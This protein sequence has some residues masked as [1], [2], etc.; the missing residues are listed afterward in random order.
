[1]LILESS[2]DLFASDENSIEAQPVESTATFG[3]KA[4][5]R[6]RKSKHVWTEDQDRQLL[7]CV[8]LYGDKTWRR[9]S[10]LIGKT[11]IRCHNRYLELMKGKAQPKTKWTPEEDEILT[12][13]V[14]ERG[15]R[16][17][18][19]SKLIPGRIGKQCRERFLNRLN[20][21]IKKSCWTEEED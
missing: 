1:M 2:S 11:E 14:A 17:S 10:N 4:S 12:K 9:I 7:E 20:P 8:K 19:I 18:E 15:Y 5:K 16:W 3:Q 6:N 13:A 21:Q